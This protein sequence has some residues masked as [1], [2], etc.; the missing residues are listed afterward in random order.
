MIHHHGSGGAMTT[1]NSHH[2][3]V[4]TGSGLISY[5]QLGDPS[6]LLLAQS[7]KAA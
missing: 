5:Q 6:Q 7:T 3:A 1:K 2:H 4:T